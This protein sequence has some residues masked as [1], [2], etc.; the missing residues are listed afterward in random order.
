VE[1]TAALL[2]SQPHWLWGFEHGVNEHRVAIGNE[3]VFAREPLGAT[4]LLGMDLVRLGLERGRTAEDALVV[5]TT[6]LETHG[7]GGSGQPHLDWPYHN[8]FLVADPREAWVLETS[9]RHWA[10]RRVRSVGNISNGI[11]LA[12]D[13]ERGSPDLTAFAVERGWWP[14]GGERVDFAAAYR[15]EATVPPNLWR[16]RCRRAA[17]LLAEARGQLSPAALK[18]ILRDHYDSGSILPRRA[19]DDPLFFSL[20][21]HAD[22]LDNTTAAMV[23]RLPADPAIPATAWVC[24]GNPCVGV[25][26]PCYLDGTVPAALGRGDEHP[27]AASPWWGM[28]DLLTL[29]ERDP[30]RLAPLVRRRWDELETTLAAET[31]AI[32]AEAIALRRARRHD[33]AA[34]TLTAFMERTL[35]RIL[36]VFE[37]LV[38]EID[39]G[40]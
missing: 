33:E 10:A 39:G 38:R 36:D 15:E 32:E 25:F 6:L 37:V 13:W 35:G 27:S 26:M 2:G 24:L 14:A 31:A 28:R 7:Q 23:A 30:S 16:E 29:V 22:P 1:E 17:A 21:M 5:M 19:P 18:A 40:A 34:R 11:A 9:A 4:G 8:A 12:A 20:C 3:M